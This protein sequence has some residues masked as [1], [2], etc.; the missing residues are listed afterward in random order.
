MVDN[1]WNKFNGHRVDDIELQ[2]S[3]VDVI[4][5]ARGKRVYVDEKIKNSGN[6]NS[7]PFP[8]PSVEILPNAEYT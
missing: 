3:G 8:Y 1:F 6:I 5:E 7:E 4:L 2:K